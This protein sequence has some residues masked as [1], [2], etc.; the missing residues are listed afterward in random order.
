MKKISLWW[1]EAKARW[2]ARTPKVFKRVQRACAFIATVAL[3]INSFCAMGGAIMP[4]WWITVYPYLL[5]ACAA[6]WA[7]YQFTQQYDNDG[8]PIMPDVKPTTKRKKKSAKKE[9][10]NT[11][12]DRDDF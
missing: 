6:L 1:K 10:K 5:G 4:E 12:L 8:K 2:K 9:S 7:G 3:G 11:I